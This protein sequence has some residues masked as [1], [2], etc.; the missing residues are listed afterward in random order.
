MV[1]AWNDGIRFLLVSSTPLDAPVVWYGPI[2]HKAGLQ[3]KSNIIL[4]I[5]I[6]SR[7]VLTVWAG[8]YS[9]YAQI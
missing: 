1:P 9:Y 6:F 5:Y 8:A 7:N 4:D 2:G 3:L